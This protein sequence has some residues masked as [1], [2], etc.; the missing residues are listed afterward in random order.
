[1]NITFK[2][3][4]LSIVKTCYCVE[5]VELEFIFYYNQ[6]TKFIFHYFLCMLVLETFLLYKV[7]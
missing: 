5:L 6:P 2:N 3:N 7:F 4:H 1:M